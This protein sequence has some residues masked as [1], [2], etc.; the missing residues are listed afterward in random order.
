M[1]ATPKG[2]RTRALILEAARRIFARDGYVAARMSDIADEAALSLGAVYRYFENKENVFSDLVLDIHE[3][4]F[5][6]SRARAHSLKVDPYGALY[7]S[8]LGYLLHYFDNR[9]VMRCLVE[10]ATV[11]ARFRDQW[12][13]MR[14]RHV[15]RFI[16]VARASFGKRAF[17]G[18]DLELAAD[19]MAC[20][21]EQAAY[22]WFANEAVAT[23]LV[24]PEEAAAVLTRAWVRTIFAEPWDSLSASGTRL[25]RERSD[26]KS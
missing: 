14:G 20:M 1:P 10:A 8:N 4:L 17:S 13:Q 22:V 3:E 21:V 26:G 5:D 2:V 9:D 24:V 25:A 16:S 12:W 23:R 11:D 7:E 18:V 6:A 15:Q 19:A